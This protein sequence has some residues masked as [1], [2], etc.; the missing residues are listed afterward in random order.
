MFQSR[1]AGQLRGGNLQTITARIQVRKGYHTAHARSE[2]LEFRVHRSGEKIGCVIGGKVG[3]S[4][5]QPRIRRAVRVNKVRG[6][7]G[8]VVIGMHLGDGRDSQTFAWR[9]GRVLQLQLRKRVPLVL[10]M[11]KY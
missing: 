8:S 6:A 4:P 1:A 10:S 11:I 2:I 9:K 5:K 3:A 7:I